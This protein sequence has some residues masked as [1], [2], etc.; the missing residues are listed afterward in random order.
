LSPPSREGFYKYKAKPIT[1]KPR[2]HGP[3]PPCWIWL[4]A[5]DTLT[6]AAEV[7]TD[8]DDALDVLVL[9]A[10]AKE[11]EDLVIEADT[12]PVV[13]DAK[14]DA[15][16]ELSGVMEPVKSFQTA[17]DLDGSGYALPRFH[18]DC[19][20]FKDKF[21]DLP[22]DFSWQREERTMRSVTARI[23]HGETR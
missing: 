8:K 14:L 18:E 23:T 13:V 21:V 1:T 10:V 12:S 16:A 20:S 17:G 9:V 6:E 5:L 3:A 4:L 2:R 19:V 22:A 15:G 11:A 7:K